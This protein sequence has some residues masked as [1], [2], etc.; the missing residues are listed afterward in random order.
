[1]GNNWGGVD[2][3]DGMSHGVDGVVG[4]GVDGVVD[5]RGVVDSVVDGSVVEHMLDSSVGGSQGENSSS[6]KS[7]KSLGLNAGSDWRTGELARGEERNIY[8]HFCS[9]VV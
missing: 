2:S 9:I 6:N 7:L 8:L 5:H 4:D 3:V 1:M